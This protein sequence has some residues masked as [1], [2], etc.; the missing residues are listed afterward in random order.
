MSAF[1][2]LL[3]KTELHTIREVQQ[4]C[5]CVLVLCVLVL[6]ISNMY[7]LIIT[8]LYILCIHG[9]WS[10]KTKQT[11]GKERILR[12]LHWRMPKLSAYSTEAPSE[13]V[14]VSTVMQK[15]NTYRDREK[16][17]VR[18][19]E[20]CRLSVGATW[21]CHS[22]TRCVTLK[23]DNADELPTRPHRPLNNCHNCL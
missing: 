23:H 6:I 2:N 11:T 15:T 7:M 17:S 8:S 9:N 5:G 4:N 12:R 13:R 1:V 18:G 20:V 14:D 22:N 21:S 19:R 16:E 3:K 10:Q